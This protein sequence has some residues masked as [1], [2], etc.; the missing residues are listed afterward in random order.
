MICRTLK[1][2]V[3][4]ATGAIL[5]GGLLLGGDL[6]SYVR[7]GVSSVRQE[8]RS[9]IPIEVELER[10][11]ELIRE[12][13]PEL[14]S[15][16][17]LIVGEEMAVA[18]LQKEIELAS[19]NLINQRQQVVMLKSQL[20]DTQN[21]SLVVGQRTMPR[22]KVVEKLASRVSRFKQAQAQLDSK[23]NCLLYTS[24]SPRDS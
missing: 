6:V 19:S 11:K 3:A 23:Q 5:L 9:A 20:G 15:N 24:P 12:I 18:G 16:I 13:T 21:V 2:G 8:V 14:Q 10:A 22:G 7:T 17:Q 4:A 1:M